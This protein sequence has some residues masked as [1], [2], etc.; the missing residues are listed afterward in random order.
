MLHLAL[1]T[2]LRLPSLP[3]PQIVDEAD[4]LN[5]LPDEKGDDKTGS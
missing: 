5:S 3:V 1:A 2:G 4:A